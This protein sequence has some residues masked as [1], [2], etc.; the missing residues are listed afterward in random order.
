MPFKLIISL[1]LLLVLGCQAKPENLT[2]VPELIPFH[3]DG[4][5]GYINKNRKIIIPA[6]FQG[7]EL[8]EGDHAFVQVGEKQ[9]VIDKKGN[10]I[11]SPDYELGW[12]SMPFLEGLSPAKDPKTGLTGYMNKKGQWEIKPQ[13]NQG[14]N[15]S[16]GV[17]AVVIEEGKSWVFINKKGEILS[18]PRP[19]SRGDDFYFG[20]T[21]IQSITGQGLVN[22]YGRE[23]LTPT[24]GEVS[25]RTANLIQVRNGNDQTSGLVDSTGKE[26]L[27]MKYNIN[28]SQNGYLSVSAGKKTGV[29]D[30]TG[31]F[32]IPL[33]YERLFLVGD[34]LALV[35]DSISE[36]L[37]MKVY[38]HFIDMKGKAITTTNKFNGIPKRCTE[39]FCI[40]EDIKIDLTGQSPG[41]YPEYSFVKLNG[42]EITKDK[43]PDVGFFSDG[44]APINDKNM[45][46][47]FINSSGKIVIKCQY[48]L[49]SY[50]GAP[51]FTYFKNGICLVARDG[52]SFYIDKAGNEYIAE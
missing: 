3:K 33:K 22:R 35:M 2:N 14:F 25:I 40:V 45:K 43:F 26:L 18:K 11:I 17:A 49:K 7:V 28:E 5:W 6:K 13:F 50:R 15:F 42:E 10:Y 20:M 16:Q 19:F 37:D 8:F 29:I 41:L 27:L 47:G 34:N 21:V 1:F 46:M 38:G 52:K 48:D 30:S 4:K 39:N 9:A 24:Y 44:M 36:G 32:V 51:E 23:V 31:K 12:Y